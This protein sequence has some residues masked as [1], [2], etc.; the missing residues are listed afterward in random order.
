[1]NALKTSRL[2]FGGHMVR[3]PE[4]SPQKTVALVVGVNSDS[5]ALGATEWT[6]RAQDREYL[7]D[8]YYHTAWQLILLMYNKLLML[9]Q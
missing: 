4:D 6:S 5:R 7:S 1:M 8:Y 2:R 3:R 9:F